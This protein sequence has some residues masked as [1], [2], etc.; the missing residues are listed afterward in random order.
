MTT[1]LRIWKCVE[2][3]SHGLIVSTTQ[4][5]YQKGLRKTV[6]NLSKDF[7]YEAGMLPLD[8]EIWSMFRYSFPRFFLMPHTVI[9]RTVSAV[10]VHAFFTNDAA[11]YF[12]NTKGPG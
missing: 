9:T 8:G 7:E 12:H 3:N 1:E 5:C 4:A 6:I 10:Q 11:T 2:G